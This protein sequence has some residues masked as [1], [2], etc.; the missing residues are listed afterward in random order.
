[1]GELDTILLKLLMLEDVNSAEVVLEFVDVLLAEFDTLEEPILLLLEV[2]NEE[3]VNVLEI[4][5]LSVN[6]ELLDGNSDDDT[7]TLEDSECDS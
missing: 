3:P 5:S 2:F 1:M 4:V 6:R 7:E